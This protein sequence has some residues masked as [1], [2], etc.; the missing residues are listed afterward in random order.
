MSNNKLSVWILTALVI[1]N[2]VGSGIFMLPSSLAKVASPGGV[3]YA[4]LFTGVGVLFIALVYGIL[5]IKRTSLTGGPQIYAK[6]L[7]KEGSN[8]SVLWGYLVSWGYWVANFVGIVAV[9]TTFAGYLSTFFPIMNSNYLLFNLGSLPV[10]AGH[11]LNFLVCS[12]LLWGVHYLVLK[13]FQSAGRINFIA[14]AAKVLGFFLFII[15]T[16]FAFQASHLV[17]FVT[18]TVQ[19]DG[20][21]TGLFGQLNQAAITTLWAFVGVE[22]A[23]AF[24]KRAKSGRDIKR[25]TIAGLL[26]ALV[27][28]MGITL[29]VIGTL[30]HS[31]LIHSSKPLVD[32]LD[33]VMGQAGGYVLAGLALVSLFG[34]TV[35][36]VLLTA[37]VPYQSAKQGLFM[38]SFKKTNASGTPVTSLMITNVMCQVF[39]FSTLSQSI[40]SAFDFIIYIATL[41]YLLPYVIASI[42]VLKMVISGD[43][44]G[45]KDRSRILD[46]IIGVLATIYSLWVIKAGTADLKT[47]LFGVIMIL[48]GFVFYPLV[49]K[50][51]KEAEVVSVETAKAVNE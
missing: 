12:V 22:S 27:I 7:F 29:L 19:S 1:G 47:F 30:T 40:S 16:L 6:A 13:G 41:S 31:E 39:I 10:T 33:K 25:A 18:D 45:L 26:I 5:S 28:Y 46:G 42:L 32:A 15:V 8:A 38:K 48:A 21:T 23:V 37:E 34:S 44:Y 9:I 49:L 20:Q 51:R 17:P 4:W 24:S 11:L 3:F 14:T 43:G 50:S 36:W 35:G 2:M